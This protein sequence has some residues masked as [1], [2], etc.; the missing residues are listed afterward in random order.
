LAEPRTERQSVARVERSGEM[1]NGRAS[2]HRRSRMSLALHPDYKLLVARQQRWL[3]HEECIDQAFVNIFAYLPDEIFREVSPGPDGG[4]SVR[5]RQVA[6][7]DG[8]GRGN[9]CTNPARDTVSNIVPSQVG[10]VHETGRLPPVRF[11]ISRAYSSRVI[12]SLPAC[13]F[14]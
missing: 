8:G 12:A 2:F 9:I 11:R 1:R 7:K 3:L 5:A 10:V 13:A 14:P 4:N 6:L